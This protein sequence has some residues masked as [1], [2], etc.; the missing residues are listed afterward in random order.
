VQKLER[1]V[2]IILLL[3]ATGFGQAFIDDQAATSDGG[4]QPVVQAVFGLIYIF[5][6]V[7]L[8]KYRTAVVRLVLRERWTAAICLWALASV[9]WSVGPLESLRRALA[10]TGTYAAGLYLAMKYEP[11]QQLRMMAFVLGLGAVASVAAAILFPSVAFMPDGRLQGVYFMKNSLGRMMSLGAF[12]FALLALGERRHR[13]VRVAMFLLCCALLLVSKSAT[14]VVVTLLMLALLPLR[15]L[16]YLSTRK[17]VYVAAIV[18]PIAAAGVFWAV[19]Y[20]DEIFLSLGRDSSLTGRIPLWQL[21]LKEIAL[22]PIRGYG[23]DAY[24]DSW[25][26][27]RVSDTVNWDVAV[28]HAHNGFLEV[29]LG[30]GLVG[31][32]MILINLSRNFILALRTARSHREAESSWPLLLVVFTVLYNLT[33]V[34][35]LGVNS[36]PWMAYGAVTFWLVRAAHEEKLALEPQPE[37]EPAYSG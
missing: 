7:C 17:L 23:F 26:G 33:E 8:V 14:A 5:V 27:H 9:L 31:L 28:P 37:A 18:F 12:C 34:S 1:I 32:A 21:V 4:G 10:L 3:F 29:W 24:W 13:V 19:E 16:L 35:L 20:S 25:E 2:I 36:M 11:K 30:L 6:V 22:R 15:R